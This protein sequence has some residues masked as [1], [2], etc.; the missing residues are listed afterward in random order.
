MV[1]CGLG[2]TRPALDETEPA[3]GRQ[4]SVIREAR[5]EIGSGGRGTTRRQPLTSP[6]VASAVGGMDRQSIRVDR[7]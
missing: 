5:G 7:C 3:S 1:S 2:T 6:G 4:G